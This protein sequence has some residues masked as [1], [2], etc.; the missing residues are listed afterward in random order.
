MPFM[1]DISHQKRAIELYGPS[2][3]PIGIVEKAGTDELNVERFDEPS[4][5]EKFKAVTTIQIA[6]SR[7]TR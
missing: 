4:L 2:R 6:G 7:I 3:K 1:F 5:R